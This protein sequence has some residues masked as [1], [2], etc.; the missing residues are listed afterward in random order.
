MTDLESSSHAEHA[1]VR[2]LGRQTLERELDDFIL[3]RDEIVGSN[4]RSVGALNA[5]DGLSMEGGDRRTLDQPFDSR[6]H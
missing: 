3:L 5:R 2:F 1:I 4:K 6:R